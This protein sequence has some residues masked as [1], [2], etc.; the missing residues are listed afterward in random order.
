[1]S[2]TV[3]WYYLQLDKER[4]RHARDRAAAEEMMRSRDDLQE[5]LDSL[6]AANRR[7]V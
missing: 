2:L 6:D 7:G 5:Q 1:M 3:Y 4:A